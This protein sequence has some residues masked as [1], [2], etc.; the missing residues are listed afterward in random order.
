VKSVFSYFFF[1]GTQIK[2]P[3]EVEKLVL[4]AYSHFIHSKEAK[5]GRYSQRETET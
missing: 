1:R 4:E 5:P 2:R 3:I